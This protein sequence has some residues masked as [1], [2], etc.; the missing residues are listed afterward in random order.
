MPSKQPF[1]VV[2][3]RSMRLIRSRLQPSHVHHKSRGTR[4][5]WLI[6]QSPN[7]TR[8]TSHQGHDLVL[9][10]LTFLQR[11]RRLRLRSAGTNQLHSK[12][13]LLQYLHLREG[14]LPLDTS[15]EET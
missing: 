13:E 2:S 11:Y 8:G 3:V 12:T 7:K 14:F 1:L 15:Q 9:K 4:H 10:G 5:D 6:C